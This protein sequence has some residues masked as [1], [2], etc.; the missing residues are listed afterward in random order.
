MILGANTTCGYSSGFSVYSSDAQVV[1]LYK[2]PGWLGPA[3]FPKSWLGCCFL[4][5]TESKKRACFRKE[6]HLYYAHSVGLVIMGV[7]RVD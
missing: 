3:S 1:P 5:Y 2:G 6:N 4:S 7:C